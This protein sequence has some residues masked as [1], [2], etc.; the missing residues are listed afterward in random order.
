MK[1]SNYINCGHV[2]QVVKHLG[3]PHYNNNLVRVCTVIL[4]KDLSYSTPIVF[5]HISLS[6]SCLH[7]LT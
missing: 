1:H 4:L 5:V 6:S 2:V 7:N 3:L